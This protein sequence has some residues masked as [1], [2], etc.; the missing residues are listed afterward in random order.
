MALKLAQINI[1][2]RAPSGGVI[3]KAHKTGEPTGI[4]KAGR[5][6]EKLPSKRQC[7]AIP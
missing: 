7:V 6:S 5:R 1:D 4:P 2:A 3:V